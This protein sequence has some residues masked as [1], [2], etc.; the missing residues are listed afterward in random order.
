MGQKGFN[1]LLRVNGDGDHSAKQNMIQQ[2]IE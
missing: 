2:Q 1:G